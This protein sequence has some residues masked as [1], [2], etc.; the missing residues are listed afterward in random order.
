MK[1]CKAGHFALISADRRPRYFGLPAGSP[2]VPRP[3]PVPGQPGGPGRVVRFLA[4]EAGIRQFLDIGTGILA[5]DNTYEVAQSVAWRPA[6]DREAAARS[7]M[8]GGVGR[9]R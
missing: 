4:A 7:A 1:A 9:K 3:S 6:S 2:L 8:W 5:A